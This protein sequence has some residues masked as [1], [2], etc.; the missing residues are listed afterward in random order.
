MSGPMRRI[1]V[2]VALVASAVVPGVAQR[3]SEYE[4]KAAFL[5]SF[6][7]FVEWPGGGAAPASFSICVLGDD[8]FGRRLDDAAVGATIKDRPVVIRRLGQVAEAAGC[9]TVFVAASDPARVG[10]I[11]AAL[12]PLPVLTVGDAAQFAERGGMLGFTAQGG[13]VRFVA[14]PDAARAAGLV[15]TSELLRVAAA[16]VGHPSTKE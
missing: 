7:K 13:R 4:V 9:Q 1:V 14:N 8:P 16:V 3:H 11:L 5:R 2:V 6:G 15:L 12:R 10:A